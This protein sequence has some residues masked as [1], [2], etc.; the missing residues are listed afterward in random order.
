MKLFKCVLFFYKSD[1]NETVSQSLTDFQSVIGLI[2]YRAYIVLKNE[3]IYRLF[4]HF[5]IFHKFTKY[6]LF[7]ALQALYNIIWVSFF[8]LIKEKLV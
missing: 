2:I 6:G 4:K 5:K 1:L 8:Y 7:R 3:A